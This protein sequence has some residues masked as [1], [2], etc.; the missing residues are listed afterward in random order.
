M[1][2][3][4]IKCINGDYV[5]NLNQISLSCINLKTKTLYEDE[6]RKKDL[7]NRA[8]CVFKSKD[9]KVYAGRQDGLY[10]FEGEKQI[11]IKSLRITLFI[12]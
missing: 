4:P 12:R 5:Y 3:Q 9:N 6:L 8:Y 2:N 7:L 1:T 10:I 11:K